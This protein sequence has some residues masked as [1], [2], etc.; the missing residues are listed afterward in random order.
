MVILCTLIFGVTSASF[1]ETRTDENKLQSVEALGR[2][3]YPFPL[4]F[5]RPQTVSN[6][7]LHLKLMP[8]AHFDDAILR[9]SRGD[10][11]FQDIVVSSITRHEYSTRPFA[12]AKVLELIDLD[13]NDEL[14][15]IFSTSHQA[16]GGIDLFTYII[17]YD[18]T[19][20][21]Y[22]TIPIFHWIT[23]ID[24]K[25][26]YFSKPTFLSHDTDLFL[27]MVSMFSFASFIYSPIQL[28]QFTDNELIDVTDSYQNIVLDDAEYWLAK[29]E[30]R[31]PHLSPDYTQITGR[32][33]HDTSLQPE[34]VK[35]FYLTSYLV[36]MYRLQRE[37]EGWETLKEL[38]NESDNC[39]L[40]FNYLAKSLIDAGY[41]ETWPKEVD[42]AYPG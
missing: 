26:S 31:I 7:Y 2:P 22:F 1:K 8:N 11:W 27:E 21:A 9:I 5:F 37:S 29:A 15:I 4:D 38:C 10:S 34:N 20:G 6:G 33:M 3:L 42:K 36:N 32:D 12:S 18:E 24:N 14:E 41:T 35:R 13:Q 17:Y 40:F 28:L 25:P 39:E 23:L 30:S 16:G 19:L